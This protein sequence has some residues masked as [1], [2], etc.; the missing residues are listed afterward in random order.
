MQNQASWLTRT[1]K[2]W[3]IPIVIGGI[4]LYC[5]AESEKFQRLPG[6]QKLIAGAIVIAVPEVVV[7]LGRRLFGR[8]TRSRGRAAQSAGRDWDGQ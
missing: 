2:G 5:L 1:R 7:W 8:A 3:T 4:L 6:H